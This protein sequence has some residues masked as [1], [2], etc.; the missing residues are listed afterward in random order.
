MRTGSLTRGGGVEFENVEGRVERVR[1]RGGLLVCLCCWYVCISPITSFAS[2][3]RMLTPLCWRGCIASGML[4]AAVAFIGVENSM[5]RPVAVMSG[6][7]FNPIRPLGIAH[8]E[9]D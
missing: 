1:A 3:P 8:G 4:L 5:D 7:G 2:T 9:K 6:F